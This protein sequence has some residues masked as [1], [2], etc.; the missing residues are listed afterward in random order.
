MQEIAIRLW[1]DRHWRASRERVEAT[2]AR[3][4]EYGRRQ[5]RWDLCG[6]CA[7]EL[8]AMAGE[9]LGSA[10]GEDA[11]PRATAGFKPGGRQSRNFYRD[12]RRWADGQGR[13]GST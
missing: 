1:C 12:L 8:D 6:A 11:R 13:G 5:G 2:E 10:Q 3:A 9:W 7:G 4:M